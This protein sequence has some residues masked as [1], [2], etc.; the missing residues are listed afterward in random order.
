MRI[1]FNDND[2]MCSPY[3]S[4]NVSNSEGISMQP[5]QA[6]GLRSGLMTAGIPQAQAYQALINNGEPT[7]SPAVLPQATAMFPAWAIDSTLPNF[8]RPTGPTEIIAPPPPPL[9]STN[10]MQTHSFGQHG[11]AGGNMHHVA[12]S[13]AMPQ[14]TIMSDN[15]AYP[16]LF[17]PDAP[18]AVITQSLQG[19]AAGPIQT[20]LFPSIGNIGAIT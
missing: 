18:T 13:R 7:D 17:C 19:A 5:A 10:L 4:L 9:D 1:G 3:L 16:A 11:A 14:S 12:M 2:D 6:A 15:Q 8:M 20:A